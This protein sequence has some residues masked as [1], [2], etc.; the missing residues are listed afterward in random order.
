MAHRARLKIRDLRFGQRLRDLI[1]E[2]DGT[3]A[4][5]S[6]RAQ[7]PKG[8]V[9]DYCQGKI[10]EGARLAEIAR[11]MGVSVEYLLGQPIPAEADRRVGDLPP[12][13]QAVV[14]I[15][16]RLDDGVQQAL[17]T[18]AQAFASPSPFKAELKMFAATVLQMGQSVLPMLTDDPHVDDDEEDDTAV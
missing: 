2:T 1:R 14:T 6:R 13:L 10:P 5:F 15:G 4:A 12:A 17:L 3:Q 16:L 8:K 11:L 9:N 18:C 7:L